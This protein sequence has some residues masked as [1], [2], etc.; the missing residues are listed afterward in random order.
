LAP[1]AKIGRLIW[2]AKLQA[3]LPLLNRPSSSLLLDPN[4]AGQADAREEGRAGRADIGV[5]ALQLVLGGQHVGTTG[6]HVRRQAGRQVGQDLGRGQTIG[7]QQVGRHV[8]AGQQGQG[9]EVLGRPGRCR[10]P[11]RCGPSRPGPLG[12]A[13]GGQRADAAVEL[14][15][16]QA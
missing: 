8:A 3:L 13:Q 14:L 16:G 6:Q 1:P 4:A 10:P 5:G 12:V 11:C 2:G 7:R 9:V 15:L